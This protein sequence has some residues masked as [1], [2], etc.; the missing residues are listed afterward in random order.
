[1]ILTAG[2]GRLLE[3]CS[4]ATCFGGRAVVGRVVN[5]AVDGCAAGDFTSTVGAGGT[6]TSGEGMEYWG[7]C[8]GG[9]VECLGRSF[10][11]IV[12]VGTTTFT[13]V[14]AFNTTAAGG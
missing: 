7:A 10:G 5:S 6:T 3:I 9:D 13:I 8:L 11:I 4:F 12:G 1:M 2:K 14:G